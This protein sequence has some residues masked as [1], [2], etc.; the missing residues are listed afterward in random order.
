M[1]A[2]GGIRHLSEK[3]NAKISSNS[4]FS[5]GPKASKMRTAGL[6]EIPMQNAV[7]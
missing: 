7:T 3:T 1:N 6:Y 2:Y 4:E 5:T